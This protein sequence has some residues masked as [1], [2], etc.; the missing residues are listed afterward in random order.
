MSSKENEFTIDIVSNDDKKITKYIKYI[1][2]KYFDDIENI[3]IKRISVSEDGLYRG[4]LKVS[5][6]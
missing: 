4:I 2:E 3:D 6:I 5:Y 1:S